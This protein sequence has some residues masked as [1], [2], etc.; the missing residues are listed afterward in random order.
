VTNSRRAWSWLGLAVVVIAL[1]LNL[2]QHRSPAGIDFHTYFAAAT[3]GLHQGWSH[4]YDQ[5]LVAVAQKMLVP[6]QWTQPFLSPPTV[7]WLVAPLTV[8]PYWIAYGIWA[9]F[10]FAGLAAALAWSGV[11]TGIGRWIAVIGALAPWWVLHAVIL[12]QVVPLVAAGVVVAWRLM[13]DERE[14]A[15]GVLLSVIFLKPN[16]AILVPVAL[17]AAGRYR[18]L[19]AWVAAGGVLAVTALMLIGP[20]G[21]SGYLSQLSSPLPRGADAL[22]L[23]GALD[24]GGAV[25]AALRVLILG[26]VLATAYRLRSAP[27]LVVPIGIVGSLIVSPYLHAS[28][29]CLLSAAAWMVW[30]ERDAVP[31]R[32]ALAAGWVVAS[33]FLFLTGIGPTLNRWPLIEWVLLLALVVAAWRPFTGTAD[34]RTRAPA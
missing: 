22:T 18:A 3:V 25:A 30:E 28:D 17:L 21:L 6:G 13:R 20:H 27:G 31:W 26:M 23:K 1:A 5:P 19:A 8:F 14:I 34:L 29:L 24:A 15:A 4:L 33:P 7:A 16:T 12:G 11:S 32:A 10:T 2:V 9:V